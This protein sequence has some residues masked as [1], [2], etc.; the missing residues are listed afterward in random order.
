MTSHARTLNGAL[1]GV[2]LATAL[3]TSPPRAEPPGTK[4]LLGVFVGRA[5]EQ[6][7][8]DGSPEQRDIEME[9]TPYQ[10]DGLKVRWTNVTLVDGRR[11]LPGV[12]R[13]RD[14]ITL[15][16]A[17]DRSFYLAGIGYDP[18]KDRE[19]PNLIQGD[20]LRWSVVADQSLAIYSF[21]I[22]EDGRYEL[23]IT[24]RG[25]SPDGIKLDFERIV[26]G[27]VAR[28]LT[29]RAVRAE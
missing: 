8:A 13:R 17:P 19:E 3:P 9:I 4:G 14:E 2:A 10:D 24:R 16:P 7:P 5:E 22:L 12:K 21:T 28:R 25:P 20:P 18:F 29:G 11:D 1:L 26:D 6:D 23:Q 27:E 15:A